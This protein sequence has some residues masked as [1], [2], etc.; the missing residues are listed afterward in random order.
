MELIM[1]MRYCMPS[2]NI[3]C[4]SSPTSS[5][6][7]PMHTS[8]TKLFEYSNNM[9]AWSKLSI[10]SKVDV[11]SNTFVAQHAYCECMCTAIIPPGLHEARGDV[12]TSITTLRAQFTSASR[13]VPAC[14]ILVWLLL[15]NL[16]C[17]VPW[18]FLGSSMNSI[19]CA[20]VTPRVHCT[21]NTARSK[22]KF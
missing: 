19:G 22:L 14:W 9:Y 18:S 1:L 16:P 4:L 6:G 3:L 7:R 20:G 2:Q 12:L 15:H 5:Y 17:R 11:Y 13:F 8:S 21:L 10:F